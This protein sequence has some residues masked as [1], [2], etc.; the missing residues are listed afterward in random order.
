M[1][2]PFR[3]PPEIMERVYQLDA[4][5]DA[6]AAR[7]ARVQEE[8]ARVWE[9]LT[10]VREKFMCGEEEPTRV[11]VA[12]LVEERARVLEARKRLQEE[13]ARL[14]AED[15]QDWIEIYEIRCCLHARAAT[16]RTG[17]VVDMKRRD[18]RV[19]G[20]EAKVDPE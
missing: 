8:H 3:V 11:E 20:V 4:R 15:A 16:V 2:N 10:R 17:N 12:R 6:R 19:D 14:T 5:L 7:F 13:M 9:E 18:E 1:P